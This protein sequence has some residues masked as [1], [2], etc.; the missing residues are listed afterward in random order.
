MGLY[1]RDVVQWLMLSGA[2][3]ACGE[4]MLAQTV[5]TFSA[6]GQMTMPRQGH[7]ATLLL[8]GRVLI[9]GGL[10]I[11]ASPFIPTNTAELYDPTTGSFTATGTMATARR[12]HT[13][14]RLPDGRVLI[15]GGYNSP[16]GS[17]LSSAEIYDP[18]TGM[19][20]ATGDMSIGRATHAAA[21]LNT[22]KVL[23]T[24]G[25]IFVPTYGSAVTAS[26]ELY[27]PA[28]GTFSRTGNMTT[29]RSSPKAALLANGQVLIA[30]GDD[31]GDY[32][33]ADL[34]DPVAG[35]FSTLAFTTFTNSALVAETA[36]LLANGSVL[37]TLQDSGGECFD[38][39][40]LQTIFYDSA[41]G[42]FSAGPNI[43]HPH[44]GSTAAQL[45]DGGVL[46]VGS[47]ND[48]AGPL[49]TA[50]VYDPVAGTFSPAGAMITAHI[51]HRATL[52]GSGQVLVTG[53]PTSTAELYQPPSVRAAP[54]LLTAPGGAP[55]QGA[56]LHGT[57][58]QV[59]SAANPAVAGEAL[60][61][62]CTG[63]IEGSLIPPQV[64]IGGQMAEVL[65]FGDAP[66]FAGLNQVNVRMP[67][68]ASGG[69]AAS[70][71]LTYLDRPSNA[72]TL[73]VQ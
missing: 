6:T 51:D 5:G 14:T 21:L 25:A 20:T 65:F 42:I 37:L 66:G 29:I 27:D 54:V 53:G 40:E 11:A 70:V 3:L 46:I 72:V 19:F 69:G 52:L 9:T 15:A 58:Q 62:F 8:D 34:Y 59:V 36:N 71:R 57:T 49:P 2:A 16:T 60:E 61:I 67:A 4:I 26:A 64:A 33:S 35:T 18:A 73:N 63:L 28:S 7:T 31:G 10:P 43:T 12:W 45:S 47:L 55:G 17:S 22:G 68:N 30:P 56:I 41:A 24:G 23:V 39:A 1:L 13:A 50:D 38:P 44:C 32:G 48:F